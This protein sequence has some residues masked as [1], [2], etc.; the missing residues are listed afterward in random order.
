M[1]DTPKVQVAIK[2]PNDVRHEFER[3]LI[4][5]FN[6]IGAETF[7]V[8]PVADA[9]IAHGGQRVSKATLYRWAG[10]MIASGALLRDAPEDHPLDVLPAE[11]AFIADIRPAHNGRMFAVVDT[12]ERC[13]KAANEVMSQARRL[14]YKPE[15]GKV[16]LMA[17]ETLRRSL[18][19]TLKLRDEILSTEAIDRFHAEVIEAIRGES[20]V[21]AAR[22]M[23]RL[24]AI[25]RDWAVGTRH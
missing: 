6:Q 1:A 10:K 5:H 9:F 16:I 23:A 18:E 11:G 24:E 22:L 17:A 8:K 21:L 19:T 20:P 4:A 25:S 3:R 2:I 14:R 7:Q 12:L 15:N 13:L